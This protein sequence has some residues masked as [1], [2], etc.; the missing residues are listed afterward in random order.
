LVHVQVYY[1]FLEIVELLPGFLEHAQVKQEAYPPK[2]TFPHQGVNWSCLI[3]DQ[4]AAH[5]ALAAARAQKPAQTG[6][7]ARTKMAQMTGHQKLAA[8]AALAALAEAAAHYPLEV[9]DP[10]YPP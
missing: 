4:E 8:Q 10:L 5:T 3:A 6:A 1:Y 7:P 2:V 9:W